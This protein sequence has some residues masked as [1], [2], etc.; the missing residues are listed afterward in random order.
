MSPY[1]FANIEV[2]SFQQCFYLRGYVF[3]QSLAN[4][5]FQQDL[6]PIPF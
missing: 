1:V 5:H 3:A 2:L 6:F 4:F